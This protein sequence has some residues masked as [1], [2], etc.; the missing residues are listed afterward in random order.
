MLLVSI[1]D[2]AFVST[3]KTMTRSPSSIVDLVEEKMDMSQGRTPVRLEKSKVDHLLNPSPYGK[4][5]VINR[6]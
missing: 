5:S 4:G 2:T 1:S 3:I 6:P